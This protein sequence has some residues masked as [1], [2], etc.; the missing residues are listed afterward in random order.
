MKLP[1]KEPL[2][3]KYLY[4]SADNIVHVLMPVVSGTNI[5]LDNTCKAV[6]SLQAF[7]GKGGDSNQK[8]TLKG[9]LMAYKEALESDISL[10]GSNSLLTSPKQERLTQI[11]A[12]L[13]V[14]TQ[15]EKH[16]ELDCL[17]QSFPSYPRPLEAIMQDRATSNL[18][19]MVLRPTEEDGYLRSEAANPI[20]SVEHKSVARNRDTTVSKFQQAL[21]NAYAALRYESNDLKSQVIQQVLTHTNTPQIPV[22]FQYLRQILTNTVQALLNEPVD[23]NFTQTQQRMPLTQLHIDM[24]M[25]FSGATTPQE[26]IEALLGYCAPNLFDDKTESPFN[27]LTQAEGWSIATQF[28]LGIVNIYGVS[29]NKVG[30]GTNFGRILDGNSNLHAY[31]KSACS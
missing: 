14:V 17:N 16:S 25:G 12:Y 24:A 21:I 28:L 6:Y 7:F 1:L 27:T 11:N 5:G 20:F 8:A 18:Y 26:Y 31:P 3:A 29:Q 9:E 10:L 2:Q 23:F 30:A 13:E 22:D 19:S 4:V 15:L